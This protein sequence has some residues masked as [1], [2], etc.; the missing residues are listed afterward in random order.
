MSLVGC[1]G[2][3]CGQVSSITAD[4]PRVIEGDFDDVDAV[5]AGIMPRCELVEFELA[6]QSPDIR[7]YELRAP[8]DL[9]GSLVFEKLSDG[10]IRIA[11]TM[12]RFRDTRR[13]QEI[14]HA[15]TH[16][17]TQLRGDVATPISDR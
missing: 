11:C 4:N 2:S 12:G 14:M 3:R 15:L 16:R 6:S 1:A 8:N 5:V 13:E 17:F 10:R 9:R 7:R